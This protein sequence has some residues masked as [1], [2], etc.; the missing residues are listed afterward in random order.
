MLG[1][2]T[3]EAAASQ[4]ATDLTASAE[5]IRQA[6]IDAAIHAYEDAGV[7]GLCSAG[8]WEAALSAL[9]ILDLAPLLEAIRQAP[10]GGSAPDRG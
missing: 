5:R 1:R 6:F 9:E 7:Q 4:A 8:R 10:A 3:C 2:R